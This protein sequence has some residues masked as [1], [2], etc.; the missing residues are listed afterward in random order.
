MGGLLSTGGAVDPPDADPDPF[1]E[2][3]VWVVWSPPLPVPAGALP[4]PAPL[5]PPPQAVKT[6]ATA[7]LTIRLFLVFTLMS[8]SMTCCRNWRVL[9]KPTGPHRFVGYWRRH[10]FTT[11]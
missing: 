1:V 9:C 8:G 5:P 4:P 7:M 10:S 3:D 6:M 2:V 11:E